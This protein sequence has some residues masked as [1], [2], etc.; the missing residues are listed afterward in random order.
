MIIS[1]RQLG[2]KK[3]PT[4]DWD[5]TPPEEWLGPGDGG[6]TLRE[7][8]TRIVQDEVAAYNQRKKEERLTAVLSQR[9]IEAAAARGK[10][11]MGGNEEWPQ[12][13][14]DAAVGEALQAFEDGLY[15]VFL[16]EVEQTDLDA[17]I[18]LKVDSTL[19]FIKLTFLTG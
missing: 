1:T 2:K 14:A 10:I 15:L 4:S 17:Q 9:E 19:T 7:L 8:L 3:P 5:Y 16:D 13:D 12:A 6:L 11:T 18:F